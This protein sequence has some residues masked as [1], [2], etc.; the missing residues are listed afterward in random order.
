MDIVRLVNKGS[1]DFTARYD[2]QLYTCKAG[3]ETLVPWAAACL[4]LGDPT[5]RDIDDRFRHRTDE[6]HRLCARMGI[7]EDVAR[8]DEVKPQIDVFPVDGGDRIEMLADDPYGKNL[9]TNIDDAGSAPAALR[10]QAEIDE[11]RRQVAEMKMAA[12]FIE[13]TDV[14]QQIGAEPTAVVAATD[15]DPIAAIPTSEPDAVPEDKPT[16]PKV[17]ARR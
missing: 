3:G 11:L 9:K 16:R 15:P 2:N 5:L 1:E 17:G 12:G 4:W 13:A 6:F 7:Y 8:W 10:Q 14:D